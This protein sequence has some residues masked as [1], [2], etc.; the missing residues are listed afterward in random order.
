M[1]RQEALNWA[2]GG[3]KSSQYF[4]NVRGGGIDV[5]GYYGFQCMDFVVAYGLILAGHRLSGNAITLTSQAVPSGWQRIKN[6][7][8]FIPEPGDI[9][10]WGLGSFAQYGH[11]GIILSANMNTF[12]SVDQNW[13]NANLTVG[14][15]PATINHNYNGF[16][17]VMRPKFD[18]EPTAPTAPGQ[19]KVG[20]VKVAYRKAA[21]TGGELIDWFDAGAVA[22]FKGFVHGQP[23]DGND[24]WFVGALT[25]GY[26]WSG[27]YT[28]S[29]TNGLPDLST[30]PAPTLQP[31]QR[32]VGSSNVNYRKV[33]FVGDNVL[34]V[35]DANAVADF[36][37]WVEGQE[38]DGNKIWF[39]GKY[40][41]GY[42]HSAGFTDSST[43]GLTKATAPTDP[44]PPTVPPET[45][46]VPI[47]AP[48]AFVADA[49]V[50]TNLEPSPNFIEGNISVNCIIVHH[51]DDPAKKPSYLGVIN[52]F[53]KKDGLAPHYV[54]DDNHITQLVRESNR[55]QHAGPNGN[56]VGIGIEFDPNGGDKMYA[57]ARAL[58]ADIRK[59][60]G[61]IPIKPHSNFVAT[62]CPGELNLAKLEPG[63]TE[64]T[65]PSPPVDSDL[66]KENNALLK[67]I[68]A[69]V[70]WIKKFL[71]DRFK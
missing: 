17:G 52:G 10:I 67:Q 25:G 65:Q 14:S 28:D 59:R 57:N 27:G 22:N 56:G 4:R 16:W 69:I 45:P 43:T 70:E 34:Q 50:V 53:L 66:D 23:V 31:Y 40:T 63:W 8:S 41:G 49:A 33:P 62:T 1:T 30:P 64:T 5:D 9:A 42:A 32:K 55:A 54:V 39:R 15:S 7:A 44:T 3:W 60:R 29:S 19:R 13:N 68:L 2:Q 51:W 37:A 24:I 36:D 12:V 48:P 61:N 26:S 21:N 35:L 58:V 11:T 71:S 38:V 46:P 20:S 6:T 18:P 47:P